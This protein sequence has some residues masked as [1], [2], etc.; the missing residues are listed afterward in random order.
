MK[1]FSVKNTKRKATLT[2]LLLNQADF[3]ASTISSDNEGGFINDK[4]VNPSW[5]YHNYK[6]M[7]IFI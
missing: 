7:H 3:K 1:T 6:S 2:G 5:I 4:M